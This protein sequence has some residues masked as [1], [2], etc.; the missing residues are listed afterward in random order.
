M[1]A[2]HKVLPACPPLINHTFYKSPEIRFRDLLSESL[3]KPPKRTII[4][5]DDPWRALKTTE[6]EKL[7][8]RLEDRPE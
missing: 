2:S 1:T 4:I 3:P 8:E 6:V 7:V 5:E